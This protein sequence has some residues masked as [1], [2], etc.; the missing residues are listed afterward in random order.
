MSSA[1]GFRVTVVDDRKEFA[2]PVRFPEA[3]RTLAT[4]YRRSFTE[5]RVRP[6]ASIVIVT[7]GHVSDDAVLEE[8]LKTPASY[9]GMIGSKT[10]VGAAFERL[11]ADGV[12]ADTLRRIRAPIG[13]DIGAVTP[14]EIA[15]SIVAELIHARRIPGSPLR[16]KHAAARS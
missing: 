9:I 3:V 7:R 1:V 13:I 5:I 14:E 10:K 2:N 12:P 8:A 15:V 16:F 6:S 11:R 4:D